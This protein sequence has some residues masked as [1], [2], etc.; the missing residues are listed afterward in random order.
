MG[1][2]SAM[3]T[4]DIL[5]RIYHLQFIYMVKHYGGAFLGRAS[6]PIDA[7][8]QAV[9]AVGLYGNIIPARMEAAY[10]RPVYP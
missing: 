3:I 9:G 4:L 1:G 5:P 7:M 8:R 10:Q 2:L 6:H